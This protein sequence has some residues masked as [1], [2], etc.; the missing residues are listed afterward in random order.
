MRFLLFASILSFSGCGSD[1]QLELFV[2][3]QTALSPGSEFDLVMTEIFADA[4]PEAVRRVEV[5]AVMG[6][7]FTTGHRAA[8]FSELDP[9]QYTVRATLMLRGSEVANRSVLVALDSTRAVTIAIGVMCSGAGCPDGG[10]DGGGLDAGMDADTAM[11]DASIMDA[12]PTDADTSASDG[13]D[14]DAPDGSASPWGFRKT[15]TIADGM[16]RGTLNDFPVLV[17]TTDADL[18]SVSMGGRVA[19]SSG[20]DIVFRD[21]DEMLPH[22]IERY[23]PATGELVA[24]VT[25]P[26]LSSTGKTFHIYFGNPAISAPTMNRADVWRAGFVGVWHMGEDAWTGAPGEVRDSTGTNPGRALGGSTTVPTGKIG[27]AGT[28]G[29]DSSNVDVGMSTTLRPTSITVS[30]W[31]NPGSVGS[32][33][34]RHP[35]MLWQDL[36]RSTG[37]NP[38]GYYIEIYRTQSD[39]RPTFYTANGTEMA[40]AF[41]TTPVVNGTWYHVV[42]TRDEVSGVT[43]IYV[44]G[45]QEGSASMTGGIAYQPNAVLV[46]GTGSQTWDG[47]LDEV[48]VANVPRSPEWI[49]TEYV[50]QLSPGSFVVFGSLETLP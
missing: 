1:T 49:Y 50:N 18:R 44:D 32:V 42:G 6:D 12:P 37:S 33:P 8:E 41:A 22:E 40:H 7:D 14:A 36:W 47:L 28:F 31:A 48:R 25:L 19:H 13:G 43:R 35:Y 11:P 45:I 16:P 39:P 27:N 3:V 5:S 24:W 4:T 26:V 38:R 10:V 20:Y 9:G 23:D 15:L 30:V 29:A 34:D 21:G 2:D 46:G 17:S